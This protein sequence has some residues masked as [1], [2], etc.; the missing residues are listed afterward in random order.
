MVIEDRE[1]K[2]LTD[3]GLTVSQAKIYLAF[4]RL[5]SSKALAVSKV[6]KLD[7]AETYRVISQLEQKGFLQKILAYPVE[8]RAV[9]L[10]D[11]LSAL[12]NGEKRRLCDLEKEAKR[13]IHSEL[14]EDVLAR[15]EESDCLVLIPNLKIATPQIVR[16]INSARKS[17]R[18]ISATSYLPVQTIPYVEALK[19]GVKVVM[20]LEKPPNGD[21]LPD[22]IQELKKYSHY[23]LYLLPH[24]PE[25]LLAVN[26][27][28]KTWVQLSG[29]DF[30][31]SAWVMSTNPRILALANAYFEKVLRE[32]TPA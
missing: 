32:S 20:I 13:L 5:G 3:L 27:D 26:D 31:D 16:S 9:P 24:L 2:V 4:S 28:R 12:L 30:S 21:A 11:L 18:I 29:S 14:S 1:I 19:R 10:K 25:V 15:T 23:E 22:Y 8:Y 17:I 7:R 6:A